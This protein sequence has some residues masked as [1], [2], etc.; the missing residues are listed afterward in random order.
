MDKLQ[1]EKLTVVK[2]VSLVLFAFREHM[3]GVVI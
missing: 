2:D 3:M 1:S